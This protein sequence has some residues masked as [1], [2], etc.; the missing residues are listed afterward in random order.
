MRLHWE[1]LTRHNVLDVREQPAFASRCVECATEASAALLSGARLR[2]ADVDLVVASQYP[3][4]FPVELSCALGVP[5]ERIPLAP[6]ALASA[7]TAGPMVALEAAIESG[8]FGEA[9]NV[10]FVTVG[11]GITTAVALYRS[12]PGRGRDP[13]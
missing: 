3:P 12:V 2:T 13:R 1:P 8:R 4:T 10:L 7:H 6:P 11:A 9:G 5:P